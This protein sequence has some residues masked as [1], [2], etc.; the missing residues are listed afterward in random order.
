METVSRGRNEKKKQS[1]G[2]WRRL[3]ISLWSVCTRKGPGKR[4]ANTEVDKTACTSETLSNILRRCDEIN[5]RVEDLQ[6]AYEQTL[7]LGASAKSSTVQ[8]LQNDAAKEN[9]LGTSE[10]CENDRC[11]VSTEHNKFKRFELTRRDSCTGSDVGRKSGGLRTEGVCREMKLILHRALEELMDKK[12]GNIDSLRVAERVLEGGDFPSDYPGVS[13]K[14]SQTN[15]S[16]D[17]ADVN[18]SHQSPKRSQVRCCCYAPPVEETYKIRDLDSRDTM[19]NMNSDFSM[20]SIHQKRSH[21]VVDWTNVRDQLASYSAPTIARNLSYRS[22]TTSTNRSSASADKL[23]ET[24]ARLR[25]EDAAQ[26]GLPNKRSV[27]TGFS[28]SLS[29][30]QCTTEPTT[31]NDTHSGMCQKCV[32]EFESR[33][34]SITGQARFASCQKAKCPINESTVQCTESGRVCNSSSQGLSSSWCSKC[35]HENR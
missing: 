13:P 27:S 29:G 12:L 4:P 17:Y 22:N 19:A 18:A 10:R 24:S 34:G 15:P 30:A 28:R 21:I 2:V 25:Y 32:E 7:K 20:D 31:Q 5:L 9:L 26:Y 11:L 33:I 3:C 16:A 1:L 14:S 6:K 8:S 23:V 35:M